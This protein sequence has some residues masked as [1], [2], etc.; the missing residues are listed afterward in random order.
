MT[1]KRSSEILEDENRKFFREK[2]KFSKFSTESYNFSKIGGNLK[3][4]ECIMASGGM[5]ASSVNTLVLAQT[6]EFL[7]DESSRTKEFLRDESSRTKEFLRHD[8][9]PSPPTVMRC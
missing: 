6:K 4:G 3:Q 7:R 5:D 1:K 2:V 8:S 9:S